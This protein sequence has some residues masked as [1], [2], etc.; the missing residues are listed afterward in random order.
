LFLFFLGF[1][2][3]FI[4]IVLFMVWY[5]RFMFQKI[6]GNTR[7][8]IDFIVS[9]GISPPEWDERL[10]KRLSKCVTEKE[11]EA[12]LVKHA[13]YAEGRVKD[14]IHFM[15]NTG[16]VES[17]GEREMTLARLESL[18][19]ALTAPDAILNSQ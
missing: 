11:K 3:I 14:L 1:T 15:K 8:Q 12:A 5:S 6:Y 10:V 2:V 18:R 17:E 16:L 19:E 4:G 9:N 7:E 13:R